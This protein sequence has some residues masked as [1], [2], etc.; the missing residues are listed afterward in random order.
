MKQLCATKKNSILWHRN[1]PQI[2]V[3][4][5][6]VVV[7][8]SGVGRWYLDHFPGSHIITPSLPPLTRT[9]ITKATPFLTQPLSRETLLSQTKICMPFLCYKTMLLLV[10]HSCWKSRQ[11]ERLTDQ[12]TDRP[13]GIQKDGVLSKQTD[14]QIK[15]IPDLQE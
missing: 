8:G 15:S 5:C 4:P 1:G 2:S 11:K 7:W 13:R 12:W 9:T 3:W 14:R 10:A 6:G